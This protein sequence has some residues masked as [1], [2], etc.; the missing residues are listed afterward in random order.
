MA[1][2]FGLSEGVK[3]VIDDVV[4]ELAFGIYQEHSSMD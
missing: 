2:T 4:H 3:A 1:G